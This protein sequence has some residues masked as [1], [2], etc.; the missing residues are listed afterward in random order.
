[1]AAITWFSVKEERN[2]PIEINEDPNSR[3]PI[4]LP[5]TTGH[6]GIVKKDI[7]NAYTSVIEIAIVN[8]ITADIN[9]PNA[10]EEILI[11]AV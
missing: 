9:L 4:K 1:M 11:G 6:S 3:I 7:T 2:T 8:T 5:I 10:I